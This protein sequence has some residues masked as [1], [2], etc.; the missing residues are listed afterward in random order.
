LQPLLARD[1]HNTTPLEMKTMMKSRGFP[2]VQKLLSKA[3]LAAGMALVCL[4]GETR[5]SAAQVLRGQRPSVVAGLP[6]VGAF[7]STSNLDL[8]ISLPLRNKPALTNLLRQIND[9]ASPNFHHYLTP[10]EFAD[11]FGPTEQDYQALKQFASDHGLRVT[12]THPN[13]TL[14][15]VKG[16]VATIQS[17]FHVKLRFYKHPSEGRNFYAPDTDPSID[18]AVSVLG[19]KGLD[20]YLLPR[21]NFK[22]SPLIPGQPPRL[23]TG[24]GPSGTYI[25]N[26]FR[27][28]YVPG[29][30]LTGAGQSVGLLE[31]DT[32][33]P[34]DILTYETNAHLPA[35]PITNV[36]L[37]EF[38]GPPG[39]GNVEVALDIDMAIS[40]APG[41]SQVLVYEGQIGDDILNRMATDDLANQLSSSWSWYP[42]DETTDQIFQ[43]FQAQGQSMFE[44]SGDSGAYSG[45]IYPPSDDPNITI[46][47]G[48]TLTTAG[49]GGSWVS[50]TVWNWFTTGEGGGGG[51][52]GGISQVYPIPLWQ[53]GIDMSKNLG[54][55]NMRNLP[56]VSMVADNVSVYA[57][58]GQLWIGGGTS[59]ATPLWAALTALANQQAAAEDRAPVGF[60]NPAIYSLARSASYGTA[61]H[62]VT[63]GNNTN[64]GDSPYFYAFPGYDLCTGWGT[65][66]GSNLINALAGPADALQITPI[67][68]FIASGVA[69]GP[70][71]PSSQVY[72]L[73]NAGANALN[74]SVMNTS[75]WLDVSMAGGLLSRGGPASPVTVSLSSAAASLPIG[76]YN[77]TV[78]FTNLAD[79][80]V[81][82]RQFTLEVMPAV[83]PSILTQPASQLAAVGSTAIFSVSA[84]G[85]APLVYQW[86]RN[87]VNLTN[88]AGISGATTGALTLSSVSA[89]NYGAYSV[90]V[91]NAYGS[92]GS[93][94]AVLSLYSVGPGG[95]LVKNGGFETGD[96][97]GWSG[98]T[99]L[100]E[101]YRGDP[102]IAY[103]GEYG[104]VLYTYGTM[105]ESIWQNLFTEPGA[106]YLISL[107]LDNLYESTNEFFVSWNGA[108]LF[109]ETNVPPNGWTNLQLYVTANMTNSVLEIGFVNETGYFG[110]DDVMAFNISVAAAPIIINQPVNQLVPARGS[111]NFSVIASGATPLTYQWWHDGAE[112]TDGPN[113]SG[114]ASANLTLANVSS[115]AAGTY[116]A[117]VSNSYGF[118]SSSG[119]VLVVLPRGESD[120]LITFDDLPETASGLPVPDGYALLDWNNFYELDGLD[121]PGSSGYTPAV[122]SPSN[123]V[124]NG[125]GEAASI[126]CNGTFDL[127]SAYLTAAW[128][129]NLQVEVQGY[130]AGA[131]LYDN[132]YTLSAVTPTP[133]HFNY[134]GV[135]E[136]DFTSFDGTAHTNYGPTPGYQFV[137]DNVTVAYISVP[138]QI[139]LEPAAQTVPVGA[140][141][142]FNVAA[143][144][145][146]PLNYQWQKNGANLSD[147]G[148]I[149]GSSTAGLTLSSV[150]LTDSGAYSAVV[151]SPAGT[152][153]TVPAAL[154]VYSLPA[155]VGQLVQ[156]G[157]FETGSFAD[158]TQGGNTDDTFVSSG[159]SYVH[160]GEYGAQLGASGGLGGSLSQTL[161]TSPGA[162]YLLSF[163]LENPGAQGPNEFLVSWNGAVVF[164]QVDVAAGGWTNVQLVV[165]A[166]SASSVLQ[167][168]FD[169]TA[170]YFGL[171][172]IS[173]SNIALAP[174]IVTQP[175]SQSVPVGSPQVQFAVGVSGAGPL[176]YQWQEN[177]SNLVAGPN[178]GGATNSTLTLSNIS[179]ASAGEY[180]VTVTTPY[181]AAASLPALLEVYALA[182]GANL[183]LNGGFET[184][185]F[186][187]W[188][189]FGDSYGLVTGAFEF[190]H[191]GSWGA[192]LLS[193]GDPGYL[194][195]YITTSAGAFYQISLWLNCPQTTS[196]HVLWNGQSLFDNPALI[197]SGWTNLQLVASTQSTNS[198]LEFV[199]TTEETYFGLDDISV[200]NLIVALPPQILIQPSPQL[201]ASGSTAVFSVGVQG[202]APLAY[203][204]Q[205]NGTNLAN[206]GQ[207][208]GAASASL[209]INNISS[210]NV[211][212]YSVIVSNSYGWTASSPATLSILPPS[213]TLITFDDLPDTTFG[214]E[215]TNGYGGL[216]WYNFD[217]IDGINYPL[218]SGYRA[219]VV[220][221][222]NVVY[223]FNG[224]T[225]VITANGR[226]DLISAYLTS[227]WNDNLQVEVQGYAAGSL[228]YDNTYTL[229]AVAPT[230]LHFNY[231]GVDELDFSSFG[232][233]PHPG[234]SNSLEQFAMDNLVV[235]PPR[236]PPQIIV[237]PAAQTVAAGS[238][239]VIG[240]TATGSPVL[241]YQ[242]QKNGISLTDDGHITGSATPSLTVANAG[243]A[244]AGFYSVVVSN[245][246]GAAASMAVPLSVYTSGQLVQNGGFE[247]GSF[248]DWTEGGSFD[249]CFV[250]STSPYVHSGRYGAELGPSTLGTLSQSIATSA[251][252]SYLISCWLYCDGE[253]PNQFLVSWNDS[254]LFDQSNIPNTGGW[255]NLVFTASATGASTV[256]QFGFLDG[257]SYLGLDD[258][259]VSAGN[260]LAAAPQITIQPTNEF[261][262]V[263]SSAAF[264]V[265]ATGTLPMLYQWQWNGANLADG[266][267]IS[268]ANSPNLAIASVAAS[269]A[270]SYSVTI[271]NTYGSALSSSATLLVLPAGVTNVNLVTF[272]DLPDTTNGLAVTNG[273]FA[274]D[275]NN[276]Y[277]IDGNGFTAYY[278]PSGFGAGVVSTNN[279]A[280]N[281]YGEPAGI[282]ANGAFSLIS[283]YLTA[284]YNDNLRLEVE[285]YIGPIRAYDRIYTL[286]AT[287]PTL[288]NFNYIGVNSVDFN[289]F[290]GTQ[291]PAY[292]NAGPLFVMDN[293]LI[294]PVAAPPQ[295]TSQP[296]SQLADVGS[297]VVFT[298]TAT[299]GLPL[300]YQWQKN[301]G[302]LTDGGNLFGST[303]SSLYLDGLVMTNAGVYSVVVANASGSVLSTGAVLTVYALAPTATELV[304]N[305]GFETG[306]FSFWT[307]SGN[308]RGTIVTFDEAYFGNYGAQLT[309]G[310]LLGG[311][312]SQ[313]LATVPNTSYLLSLWLNVP[314]DDLPDDFA[315]SWNGATIFNQVNLPALGW[316]NLQFIVA[317]STSNTVLQLGYQNDVDFLGLDDVSVRGITLPALPPAPSLQSVIFH[318]GVL[319]FSW[320]TVP[321][322]TYQVQ[323][324]S[325][326]SQSI[327]SSLGGPISAT[328]TSTN[329]TDTPGPVGQRFYRITAQ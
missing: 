242:W 323:Y 253:V 152:A 160:S 297:S 42:E 286:S 80:I 17:A 317:A 258:I 203:Q 239:A 161:S 30:T 95:Q 85:S 183:V 84:S 303:N 184:G 207:I 106:S 235:V 8:V 178:I 219:A 129:D 148:G 168:E 268:G 43:Q 322:N 77:A 189:L 217:E 112:L 104:A 181:G 252:Q 192:K 81:Q 15:D 248:A 35:V 173:V 234:Y 306:D 221:P 230:L 225:A 90:I 60:I 131:L 327:W 111:A 82:S 37:N 223:N 229:S 314:Y 236:A 319:T 325:N 273:Y 326:L 41:L 76:T 16:S 137:M 40:M 256:L 265:N 67:S 74:W 99:N 34:I 277:E 143:A 132:T 202:S 205:F 298:V 276:F 59:V 280:F 243:A 65:P 278:G 211:G 28:A 7:L 163:W 166:S 49:P 24:S 46:V 105:A 241:V 120:T 226:F 195:Q 127:I 164:D 301:G 118:V 122:V 22:K 312:L 92:T 199:F 71:T 177:G 83:A 128:N 182:P 68:G 39:S 285:G 185:D 64:A 191:S 214:L 47:G 167:F 251:G 153:A 295:I 316:T 232:G 299:G 180:S 110:L 204:W 176:T 136:V 209:T 308:T 279:V 264:S 292:T 238:S 210:T 174:V 150:A 300:T 187:D 154:V 89:G 172:D 255:T 5:A 50:E 52:S 88:G 302:N 293:M 126:I 93:A 270:G 142:V 171:D 263:G 294:A 220:S 124:Y 240:V 321:G 121:I 33:Y 313:S 296:F 123:I 159:S 165:A 227:V 246:Y 245:A 18:A 135:D 79:G 53:E 87:G 151:T 141:V 156:N 274:L 228:L 125:F 304:R 233:T 36:L 266:G 208:G 21:P 259:T 1:N 70:F 194:E 224:G 179:F 212:A 114:S 13:R 3:L 73:T 145:S 310:G 139:T 69:G 14:L 311:A 86:Q 200:S 57:D 269:N 158:W 157:G 130:V 44:A 155:G 328:T 213:Q 250:T 32:Y 146:G 305:G 56:D 186:S 307:L 282:S 31:Y 20:N 11:R 113:I 271:S 216:D 97:T 329:A 63:T 4:A 107:W 267:S 218:P 249:G 190:V 51:S 283:A 197:S 262:G 75:L 100:I 140:K 170:G 55:T 244:D 149:S 101:V 315:I 19:V 284:A 215:V 309:T 254:V 188:S 108:V 175:S 2:S 193:Y 117:S 169:N 281:G 78:W 196:F 72:S 318:G 48:T 119:A 138:P 162:T 291:D 261:A 109:E 206:G 201:L 116:S 94:E 98:D 10:A 231:I 115:A 27:A 144:G 289:A 147:G 26:D 102:A 54:S 25:G 320:S 66:S 222:S 6:A 29:V 91:S 324:T 38:S 9:P 198:A 133:L 58:D 62:D 257:P 237:Q 287:N 12:G 103:Q 134:V 260:S 45:F 61:F 288:I 23:S 290:G 272:D 275:W 96:F 247:T